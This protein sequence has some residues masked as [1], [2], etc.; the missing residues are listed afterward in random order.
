MPTRNQNRP[1]AEGP[2]ATIQ[3]NNQP[4]QVF[5]ETGTLWVEVKAV[6]SILGYRSPDDMLKMVDRQQVRK[7]TRLTPRGQK[8]VNFTSESGLYT[9]IFNSDRPVAKEFSRWVTHTVLPE[10]RRTGSFASL[11]DETEAPSDIQG[12]I[13]SMLRTREDGLYVGAMID[14]EFQLVEWKKYSFLTT[15]DRTLLDFLYLFLYRADTNFSYEGMFQYISVEM[16]SAADYLDFGLVSAAALLPGIEDVLSNTVLPPSEQAQEDVSL[17]TRRAFVKEYREPQSLTRLRQAGFFTEDDSGQMTLN[18]DRLA[19]F[20]AEFSRMQQNIARRRGVQNSLIAPDI[21]DVQERLASTTESGQTIREF[22]FQSSPIRTFEDNHL[23]WLSAKDVS[24]ALRYSGTDKLL[25]LVDDQDVRVEKLPTNGGPQKLYFINECALYRVVFTRKVPETDAFK[26][27]VTGTVLPE[28]RRTGMF[29]GAG[30]RSRLHAPAK[31][32]DLSKLVTSMF[33]GREDDVFVAYKQEGAIAARYWPLQSL[34]NYQLLGIM[35]MVILYFGKLM[36][37]YGRR[38]PSRFAPPESE[39]VENILDFD[40]PLSMFILSS[41]SY[42]LNR[43]VLPAKHLAKEMR[44]IQRD[45][46]MVRLSSC[47]DPSVELP[48]YKISRKPRK[49][50][51]PEATIPEENDTR[52][53]D[54][55]SA[56]T[57]PAKRDPGQ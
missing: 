53:A 31:T 47:F 22:S 44:L 18:H 50:A 56:D 38:G 51:N 26:T 9:A 29:V 24:D 8:L 49:Q 30:A 25:D 48:K 43:L 15:M 28:I 32:S 12:A 14:G 40:W 39:L 7:G 54:D 2:I 4:I 21:A 45:A 42:V 10:I 23:L 41:T 52:P 16:L 20:E 6:A 17:K 11:G 27:W 1:T 37:K 13:V 55:D 5:Q 34:I 19:D 57:E 33:E 35:Q 46:E 36:P 3:F